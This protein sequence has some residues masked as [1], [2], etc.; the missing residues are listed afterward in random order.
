MQFDVFP[1]RMHLTREEPSRNI[2]RFYSMMVQPDLFGGAS[3]I[4][5]W[6]RI[7]QAGQVRIDL[8]ADEGCAVDALAGL[9]QAK[10][11]RGYQ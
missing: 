9:A 3:L 4:R 2:R 6:G 5:E 7:G 10:R 11:K 8:H 1:D